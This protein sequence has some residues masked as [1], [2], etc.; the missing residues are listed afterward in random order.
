MQFVH[1]HL[2]SYYSIL[3]GEGKIENYFKKAAAD[4]QPAMALTDHGNM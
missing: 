1:L 2:H 3:D 4:H